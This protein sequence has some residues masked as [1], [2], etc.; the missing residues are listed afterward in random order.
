MRQEHFVTGESARYSAQAPLFAGVAGEF[1]LAGFEC[2]GLVAE[3]RE[4]VADRQRLLAPHF[5]YRIESRFAF[6]RVFCG[7]AATA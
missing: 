2:G 3:A 7:N 1:L 5:R 4:D 6:K